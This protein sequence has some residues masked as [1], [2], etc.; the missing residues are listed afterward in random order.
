MKKR[1]ATGC[2][3]IAA[4]LLCSCQKSWPER[5]AEEARTITET[6]CPQP[7]GDGIVLDSMGYNKERNM[8]IYYYAYSMTPDI[9]KVFMQKREDSKDELREQV[10]NSVDLKKC[11]EHNMSF[12]YH[13]TNPQTGNVILDC[14]FTP[15]DYQ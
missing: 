9:E 8:Y 5:C 11:K 4:M 1:I 13:Y 10:R 15:E 3:C 14:T 2:V 12:R 6:L 7:L